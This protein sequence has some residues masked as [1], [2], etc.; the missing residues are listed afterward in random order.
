MPSKA[1]SDLSC[2]HYE[3]AVRLTAM[4]E[5]PLLFYEEN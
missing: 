3:K 1:V 5:E 4:L 2:K